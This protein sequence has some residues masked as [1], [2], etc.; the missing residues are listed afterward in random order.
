MK[1][2]PILL[3]IKSQTSLDS[4]IPLKNQLQL[5]SLP[6]GSHFNSLQR[7]VEFGV[8]QIFEACSSDN[9][10][11]LNLGLLPVA[12]K[13]IALLN[14]AILNIQNEIT[15]PKISLE[16]PVDICTYKDGFANETS[17]LNSL[18]SYVN[19]W[20]RD[21][22]KLSILIECPDPTSTRSECKYWPSLEVYFLQIS[23]KLDGPHYQECLDFL[24]QSNRVYGTVDLKEDSF[25]NKFIDTVQRYNLL[26]KSFPIQA[27]FAANN[28]ESIEGFIVQ[29][30]LHIQKK[31]KIS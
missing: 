31:L 10:L 12:R 29:T 22:Q 3:I 2:C 21:I 14:Q 9:D 25:L 8:S 6:K 23:E 5:I 28:L 4:N 18:Q 16:L 27:L 26:F 11:S 15:F 13:N 30:F 19:S 1:E 24:C 17:F 7:L 20:I